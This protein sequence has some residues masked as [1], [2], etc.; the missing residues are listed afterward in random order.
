M[1]VNDRD[2]ETE[3]GALEP[4]AGI[5]PEALI[6]ARW[7]SARAAVEGAGDVTFLVQPLVEAVRLR[8][9]RE[10]AP[11]LVRE[12]CAVARREEDLDGYFGHY[13]KPMAL[14]RL[15]EFTSEPERTTLW[16]EAWTSAQAMS[17]RDKQV[18][19][20]QRLADLAPAAERA[21]VLR[22]AWTCAQRV[23][24]DD[25]VM[26]SLAAAVR[27][28]DLAGVNEAWDILRKRRDTDNTRRVVAA[29]A[30][31][32]VEP[33]A[34]RALALV[35]ELLATSDPLF[36]F[37]VLASIASA[38]PGDRLE[39]AWRSIDPDRYVRSPGEARTVASFV[40]ARPSLLDD[41]L[42]T[43]PPRTIGPASAGAQPPRAC[44]SWPAGRRA[45]AATWWPRTTANGTSCSAIA[46]AA[47]RTRV[48][49]R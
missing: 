46:L 4:F 1:L 43:P 20:L 47:P 42:L 13:G 18:R 24:D 31:R 36:R 11:E 25:A 35:D 8:S 17:A 16:Q 38:L 7:E 23:S 26:A 5:L 30:Q 32:L 12:A 2:A 48:R 15:V 19:V 10:P 33:P 29:A 6:R 44:R 34:R 27:H 28:A 9:C 3:A 40:I 41:V 39:A 22:T 14:A 21:E 45:R 49:V 37:G